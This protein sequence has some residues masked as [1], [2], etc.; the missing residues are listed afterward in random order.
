MYLG[1]PGQ[2]GFKR[3]IMLQLLSGAVAAVPEIEACATLSD[4]KLGG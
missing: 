1:T 3:E 2:G 4:S